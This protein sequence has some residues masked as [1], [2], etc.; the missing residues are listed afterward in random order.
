[1]LWT[2]D[3]GGEISDLPIY[4]FISLTFISTNHTIAT[5]VNWTAVKEIQQDY[6]QEE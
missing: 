5:V 6:N 3:T 4:Q 2:V 1:M